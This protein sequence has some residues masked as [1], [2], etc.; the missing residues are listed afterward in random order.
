MA[1]VREFTV[2]RA[3]IAPREPC[4][5]GRFEP[6]PRVVDPVKAEEKRKAKWA[7]QIAAEAFKRR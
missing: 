2:V 7:R 4:A 1:R 6:P 3:T 5:G